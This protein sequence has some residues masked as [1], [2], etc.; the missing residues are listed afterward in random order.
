MQNNYR[1]ILPWHVLPWQQYQQACQSNRFAHAWLL[2]GLPGMGK[3]LFAKHLAQSRLCMHVNHETKQACGEC[4]ACQLFNANNHPDFIVI[5]PEHQHGPIKIEQIRDL[6]MSLLQ[7]SQLN[8]ERIAIIEPAEAMNSAAGNALLKILEEPPSRC[9]I[10]LISHYKHLLPAT[11]HSRCH[12][13]NFPPN[14]STSTLQWLTQSNSIDAKLL[15]TLS[16][17][18]PLRAL[19][20]AEEENWQLR[21]QLF[22]DLFKLLSKQSCPIQLAKVYAEHHIEVLINQFLSWI[23]DILQIRLKV[24]DQYIT[25]QDLKNDLKE[26]SGKVDLAK[27]YS[28]HDLIVANKHLL[29]EKININLQL[30]L[31]SV[32]IQWVGAVKDGDTRKS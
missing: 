31:E 9:H 25:N 16:A 12:A 15:L 8:G 29:L 17:G 24:D 13:M 6:Q 7:T 26:L 14:F 1:E 30:L 27:L 2:S 32:F 10:I 22:T 19:N 5:H 20:L 21:Q 4:R 3:L 28:L 18:A 23:A 11:I